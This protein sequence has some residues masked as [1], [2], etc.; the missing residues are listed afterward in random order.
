MTMTAAC[1]PRRAHV[2]WLSVGLLLVFW[3]TRLIA[4]DV[5]PPFLDE[6]N[7]VWQAEMSFQS[8][9]FAYTGEGRLFTL[10]LHMLFHSYQAA[11]IWIMRSATLLVLLP[12]V[13]AVMSIGRMMAGLLGVLIAGLVY[14]FSAYH[15]FFERL[16]LADPIAASAVMVALYFA[17]RLSRRASRVDA[18]LTGIAVFVS[19]GAKATMLPYLGISVA[20]ALTLRLAGRAWRDNWRWLAIALLRM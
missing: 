19:V 12:G 9:P 14:L 13:A 16:A 10:W 8:S 5:F 11:T 15:M 20:A 4:I 2:L 17:Y 18:I 7:H 3:L 1:C 6:V